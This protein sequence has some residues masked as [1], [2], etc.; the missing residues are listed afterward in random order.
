MDW[1]NSLISWYEKEKRSLPWRASNDAYSIWISEV[2]LQQTRV[3]QGI[4]YYYRFMDSFPTLSALAADEQAV[5]H[6]WQGLG[7]YSRAR[8]LLAAAKQMHATY[9][10]NIPSDLSQLLAIKGIGPYTAAAIASLAFEI[11]V[12]VVDGNVYRVFSRF[13]GNEIEIPSTKA[14]KF[15]AS[16]LQPFIEK[17]QASLFNQAIMELGALVCLPQNPHCAQCPLQWDCF[18]KKEK[19]IADFPVKKKARAPVISYLHYFHFE[20]AG[21]KTLIYKRKNGIWTGLHEFPCIETQTPLDE[22]EGSMLLKNLDLSEDALLKKTFTS[23]HQLT[24][25]TLFATFWKIK[26]TKLP[27]IEKKTTFEIELEDISK[28]P[29]HRLMQKY[30]DYLAT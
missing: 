11:P 1:V 24:H 12:P 19:R 18:A 25:R 4:P 23:K 26:S 27:Q 21:N 5:L 15:Y 9:N 2:I 20:L 8:N 3:A 22:S 17:T 14:Q 6:I 7:Y 30:I 10:G 13:W 28:Y 29:I 16:S